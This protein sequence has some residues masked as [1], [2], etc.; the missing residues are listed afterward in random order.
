M[1]A[2]KAI[3]SS[4][5][6]GFDLIAFDADDTLWENE[7]L[8]RSGRQRLLDILQ[9]YPQATHIDDD[10]LNDLELRNLPYFGYGIDGFIFSMIEAAIQI[11]DGQIPGRDL[12]P[13]LDYA[14]EMVTAEIRVF[15][16]VS[17]TLEMLAGRY[18]LLLITKGAAHHQKAKV[19]HSGLKH[20]F[21]AVEVV[22]DKTRDI[23]ASILN[24]YRV[25]A[26]KFIMVGNSMRSDILPV[27][28]L[29]GSAIH[30]PNQLTW[31]HE[32]VDL[33][34]NYKGRYIE[35]NRFEL[36]PDVLNRLYQGEYP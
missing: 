17:E 31:S 5:L 9:H 29:G 1:T 13:L 10:V 7:A 3:N 14:R 30:I 35:I 33:P 27:L 4:A 19:E 32:Q 20:Y 24:R 2:Q 18:R 15:P 28:E 36:L 11:T 12:L 23:Y 21:N 26:E 8:Y 25:T 22:D 16:Q 6:P 34:V